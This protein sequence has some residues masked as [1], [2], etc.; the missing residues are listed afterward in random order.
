MQPKA[1]FGLFPD[2][3]QW[4]T[5]E[6]VRDTYGP[7]GRERVKSTTMT[8]QTTSTEPGAQGGVDSDAEVDD[9]SS[10]AFEEESDAESEDESSDKSSRG[11]SNE[12]M[13]GAEQPEQK[14]KGASSRKPSPTEPYLSNN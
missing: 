4:D 14:V 7:H 13:S 3:N 11:D 12:H 10:N 8:Y 1:L 2:W 5:K 6:E 9:E